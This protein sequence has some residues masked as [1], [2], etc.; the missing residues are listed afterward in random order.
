MPMHQAPFVLQ[1]KCPGFPVEAIRLSYLA[2]GRWCSLCEYKQTRLHHRM[3]FLYGKPP[4]HPG[5]APYF[6][7]SPKSIERISSGENQGFKTAKNVSE[8]G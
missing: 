1:D 8:G 6:S 2:P 4:S 5:S 3:N 7:D